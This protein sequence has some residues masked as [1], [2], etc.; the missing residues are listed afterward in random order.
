[1]ALDVWNDSIKGD[2]IAKKLGEQL[3]KLNLIK[4]ENF[5]L[6]HNELNLGN[7][8][9]TK[10]NELYFIDNENIIFVENVIPSIVKM[11]L[12]RIKRRNRIDLILEEYSKVNSE[13]N[14]DHIIKS[15]ECKNWV[16]IKK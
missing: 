14:I 13:I 8:V 4:K 11:L 5:R 15:C 2:I 16:W 12:K 3:G 6:T 7:Y 1:M 9:L 10:D